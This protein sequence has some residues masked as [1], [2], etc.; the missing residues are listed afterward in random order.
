MWASQ[1]LHV[2]LPG[3]WPTWIPQKSARSNCPGWELFRSDEQAGACSSGL[4]RSPRCS[5]QHLQHCRLATKTGLW[6]G[7]YIQSPACSVIWLLRESGPGASTASPSARSDLA[8]PSILVP[9]LEAEA[10]L[11]SSQL[12]VKSGHTVPLQNWAT[13]TIHNAIPALHGKW[14]RTIMSN[15]E[16][17]V[18]VAL[19]SAYTLVSIVP[20]ALFPAKPTEGRLGVTLYA[21]GCLPAIGVPTVFSERMARWH[22]PE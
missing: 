7:P 8:Q 12:N 3:C 17:I 5:L 19:H 15:D 14:F 20:N 11:Y 9:I 6:P 16:Y 22:K 13:A 18:L 2:S 10:S 1:E 4:V 21:H